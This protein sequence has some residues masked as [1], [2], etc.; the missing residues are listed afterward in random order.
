MATTERVTVTL[1]AELVESIDRLE[2]NRSRFI[3][4]AVGHELVRRRREGLLRSLKSPHPEAAELAETG[5]ADWA[6]SLP[7]HDEGLVDLSAGKPVRWVEGQGW[8]EE[9][10]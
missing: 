10:A 2:R 7:A 8:V 3:A 9:S 4:E 1:P 6:T 5:L